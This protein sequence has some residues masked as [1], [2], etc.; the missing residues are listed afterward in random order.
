MKVVL[1]TDNADCLVS[2]RYVTF[3]YVTLQNVV[4]C[5]YTKLVTL[6][7]VTLHYVCYEKLRFPSHVRY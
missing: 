3:R 4:L 5:C 7:C 6:S 1:H 2:N